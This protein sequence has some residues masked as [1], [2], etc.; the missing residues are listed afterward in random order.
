[1]EGFHI[2]GSGMKYI[3]APKRFDL[4]E[5]SGF[6]VPPGTMDNGMVSGLP[7]AIWIHKNN[8]PFAEHG[9][10]RIIFYFQSDG[11]FSRNVRRVE[12]RF[13]VDDMR[14]GFVCDHLTHLVPVQQWNLPNE[15]SGGLKGAI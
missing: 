15:T 5:E 9:L 13:G 10:H 7:L 3:L 2:W 1:M 6:W 4:S 11:V 12:R 14:K 8:L